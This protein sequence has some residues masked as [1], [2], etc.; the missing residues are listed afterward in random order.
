M[1]QYYI[2][3]SLDRKDYLVP[4][5]F[6]DGM[7]LTE[8]GGSGGGAME[9][10]AA[11]LV[12][13]RNRCAPWACSRI[14]IAGDYADEGTFGAPESKNLHLYVRNDETDSAEGPGRNKAGYL[15]V[16][17]EA[18]Q[19]FVT[20]EKLCSP[21][22]SLREEPFEKVTRRSTT[23]DQPED[24]F[25]MLGVEIQE[26]LATM[27]TCVLEKLSRSGRS[28]SL[29]GAHCLAAFLEVPDDTGLAPTSLKMK[30]QLSGP[31]LVTRERTLLF[32]TT[33]LEVQRFLN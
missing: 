26:N 11:L 30:Y 15:H 23:I 24:F 33:G 18:V 32:P 14:V 29:K 20:E 25:D 3:A 7:K 12:F 6:G 5:D 21:E 2:V 8:F 1:G 19:D 10:L 9:A 22:T 16:S 28:T 13:D 27:M 31:R 17:Q 4:H